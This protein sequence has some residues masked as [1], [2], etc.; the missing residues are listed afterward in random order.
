MTGVM[1]GVMRA[2]L[3]VLLEPAL[4]RPGF[5]GLAAA[6]P[7]SP[8]RITGN[9]RITPVPT[10]VPTPT[11]VSSPAHPTPRAIRVRRSPR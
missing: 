3:R 4:T 1:T 9:T 2:R 5:P 7:Q 10:L 8:H 11:P 6:L